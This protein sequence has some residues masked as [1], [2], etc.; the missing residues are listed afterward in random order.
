MALLQKFK[1]PPGATFQVVSERLFE[2]VT[3]NNSKRIDVVFDVYMQ[4]SI[5]NVER[6]KRASSASDGI[7]YK[8]ILPGYKV[9]TWSKLLCVTSNKIEI[10]RFLLLQWKNLEFRSKLFDR[11]M[12]VTGD[13]QCWKITSTTCDPVPE[14]QCNHEE[15]DTRII[16]HAQHAGGTCVIHCDD[17]DVLVL[18]L[19]H[20]Q[21]LGKCYIKK[22]KG[23]Q[24]RMIELSLIVD[25]LS[26]QLFEGI[27]QQN[28]LKALIGVHALTG[29]D[30]VSA[31][32]GKGKWR[33]VQLLQKNKEYVDAMMRI[34][35][36]W[37]LPEEVFRVTEALVCNLYGHRFDSVDLLRYKLYCAKGGKVEPEALPACQSS[38][39]L[40]VA[41]TNYQA[42]IWRSSLF[43]CPDIP[44][45]HGH[46]WNVDNGVINFVLL[47]SKPAPEEVL[48]LLPCSCK[49]ACSLQSCCCLKAGLK[50]T[51]MC[52]LQCDN[53]ASIDDNIIPD[54]SDD[55]DGGD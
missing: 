55:E 31:F 10:V 2:M 52:S 32:C 53:M 35:V 34:G 42:A 29:C 33:A 20:S 39:R 36:A 46:G 44:S 40:H 47:G 25:Y 5:K 21:S 23:S 15:A 48:E 45:P 41:R 11:A 27:S 14:L 17:T 13:D 16:L 26:N 22:G 4:V 7:K 43:A 12:Y 28:F 49:R 1:P 38:L 9:K 37:D 30:T 19:A 51:D 18:L 50:C 8:N 54:E 3:S 6:S 24:T